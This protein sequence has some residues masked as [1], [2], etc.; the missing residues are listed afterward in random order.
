MRKTTI[1]VAMLA[2]AMLAL[3]SAQAAAEPRRGGGMAAT[4]QGSGPG[5]QPSGRATK[6]KHKMHKQPFCPFGKKADGS[7][8]VRCSQVI[9][10]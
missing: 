5:I 10:L 7:C 4:S 2:A 9:C 1:A 6:A 8:W 3:A